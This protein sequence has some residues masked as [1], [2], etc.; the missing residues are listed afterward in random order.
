MRMID[1]NLGIIKKAHADDIDAYKRT[2]ASPQH[3]QRHWLL[4]RID[5]MLPYLGHMED[6]EHRHVDTEEC[7]CGL[8]KLREKLK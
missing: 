1:F 7:A 5:E 3:L 6:C 4:M 8:D 2:K